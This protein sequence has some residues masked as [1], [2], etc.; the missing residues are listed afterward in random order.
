MSESD[1]QSKQPVN[2]NQIDQTDQAQA[3][4]VQESNAQQ[5]KGAP[6][7]PPPIDPKDAMTMQFQRKLDEED[8]PKFIQ[9]GPESDD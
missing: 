9:G 7:D 4:Q 1:N 2:E 6:E 5:G 8:T 3:D